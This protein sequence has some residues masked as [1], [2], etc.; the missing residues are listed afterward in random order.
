MRHLG[1]FSIKARRQIV[2]PALQSPMYI[3][4]HDN[5]FRGWDPVLNRV[6]RLAD[7]KRD[8]AKITPLVKDADV[9]T[10]HRV[11]ATRIRGPDIPWVL[12]VDRNAGTSRRFSLHVFHE[13][14]RGGTGPVS[15]DIRSR[16][17]NNIRRHAEIAPECPIHDR[18]LYPPLF[19]SC[20]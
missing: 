14:R 1:G 2:I 19:R 8:T 3:V 4:D 7:G 12:V 6:E 17:A 18:F 9:V 5:G 13:R 16:T 11:D 20:L 15:K 10:W